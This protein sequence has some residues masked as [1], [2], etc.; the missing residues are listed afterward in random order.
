[1]VK[2]LRFGIFPKVLVTMVTVAVIPLGAI[3]YVNYRSSV[4]RL[5]SQVDQHLAARADAIGSYVDAWV[6]MNVK[7][8]RQNAVLDDI[9]SMDAR[10]QRRVL[11]SITNEYKAVYLAFTVGLDGVNV[12][13]SDQESPKNYGDRIYVQQVLRGAALGQQVVISRTNGQPA[14]ILSVPIEVA[15]RLA[16][17]LAIGMTI[18]DVSTSI[19]N[20][21]IGRTGYAFLLDSTGKVIAHQQKDYVGALKD[22]S[23]HPVFLG[24][25]AVD[26]KRVSYRN[27]QGRP[28][29]GYAHKS[30]HGWTLVVQQDAEEAYAPIA[31]A[32]R[33]ALVLL[34]FTLVF[35]ALVSFFL[36][37]RLT[38]PIRSLTRT[39]DDLSR[40]NLKAAIPGVNRADE[41][42]ALARAVDRMG[43]SIKVAMTRL[44]PARAESVSGG[45]G[46]W[47]RPGVNLADQPRS[48]G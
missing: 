18:N 28:V 46:V 45:A 30:K 17:V 42:G 5:S 16:G 29:L 40:G 26:S 19:T 21:R 1:M 20:V 48:S 2:R 24:T 13:R 15:Q 41:I 3:W 33:N 11:Q 34:A 47:R 10:R 9:A 12:G 4:D 35:V 7:M 43:A 38:R 27:E 25:S 39:A 14:L 44:A 22:L 31:E 36:A 8:L 6:D 23:Q 37:Q 32:N